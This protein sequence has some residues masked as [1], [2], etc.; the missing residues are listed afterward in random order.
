MEKIWFLCLS[1]KDVIETDVNWVSGFSNSFHYGLPSVMGLMIL[2]N[3]QKGQ[4][5]RSNGLPLDYR[6]KIKSC[7]RCR[8]K[9]WSNKRHRGCE[10]L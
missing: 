1:Q 10:G 3:V 5:P 4:P 2:N 9:V 6:N 7:L 8:G